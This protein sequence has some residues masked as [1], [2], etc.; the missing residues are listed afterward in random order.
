MLA[1]KRVV[2]KISTSFRAFKDGTEDTDVQMI[3]SAGDRSDIT[4]EDTI[5]TT[6]LF[7]CYAKHAFLD[8]WAEYCSGKLI[9]FPKSY[10]HDELYHLIVNGLAVFEKSQWILTKY[11]HCIRISEVILDGNKKSYTLCVGRDD[12][13]E[14]SIYESLVTAMIFGLC[15]T[16][17]HSKPKAQ[18]TIYGILVLKDGRIKAYKVSNAKSGVIPIIVYRGPGIKIIDNPLEVCEIIEYMFAH[19]FPSVTDT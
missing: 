8:H 17:Y 18:I 4:I 2:R 7:F 3:R 6:E 1:V 16:A 9:I 14:C 5:F 13:G 15:S 12:C 10:S 11:S 19:T